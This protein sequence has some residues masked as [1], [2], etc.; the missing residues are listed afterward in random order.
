MSW[1]GDIEDAEQ[2][3]N[4]V[5]GGGSLNNFFSGSS[6]E[7]WDHL[8]IKLKSLEP[9]REQKYQEGDIIFFHQDV[10]AGTTLTPIYSA[11]R[12]Y[13]QTGT[14]DWEVTTAK[15]EVL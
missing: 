9:W 3:Q 12:L 1:R 7:I 6:R 15:E 5:K 2:E 10:A 11:L 14:A 13:G 4:G 8:Q